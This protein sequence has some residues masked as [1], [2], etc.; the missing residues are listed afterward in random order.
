MS[1]NRI[2]LDVETSQVF[3]RHM[4]LIG[5]RPPEGWQAGFIR[6]MQGCCPYCVKPITFADYRGITGLRML[7][8]S[9]TNGCNP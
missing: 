9:C 4:N 6:L 7:T 3:L 1:Q 2:F 5:T 8:W